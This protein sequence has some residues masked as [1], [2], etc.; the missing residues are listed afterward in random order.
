MTTVRRATHSDAKA[1]V[2]IIMETHG[3]HVSR[4][5]T[6]TQVE[7]ILNAAKRREDYVVRVVDRDGKVHGFLAAMHVMQQGLWEDQSVWQVQFF[8]G[9][10]VLRPLLHD[11][12][13]LAGDASILI[14]VWWQD[15]PRAGS[16]NAALTRM[17]F[18]ECGTTLMAGVKP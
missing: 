16:M 9:K 4:R 15:D 13:R 14:A 3:A 6:V 10:N 17:G 2:G 8:M 1:L 7:R 12:R 11:L 18:A 5:G